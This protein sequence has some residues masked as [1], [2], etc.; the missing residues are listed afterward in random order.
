M[1]LQMKKGKDG[2]FLLFSVMLLA[3]H[4]TKTTI[5]YL[6]IGKIQTLSFRETLAFK[7]NL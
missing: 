7:L 2:I 4:F 3:M 5:V 1:G 6:P